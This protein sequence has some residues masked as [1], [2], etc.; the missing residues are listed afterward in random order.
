[1][2]EDKIAEWKKPTGGKV[3]SAG[4]VKLDVD[5]LRNVKE[6][7]DKLLEKERAAKESNRMDYAKLV[8]EAIKIKEMMVTESEAPKDLKNIALKALL[9]PIHRSSVETSYVT[10]LK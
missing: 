2:I 9:K 3:F 1:M 6:N 10:K 7:K 8:A 5:I 4:E